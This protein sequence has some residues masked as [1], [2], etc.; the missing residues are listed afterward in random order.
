MEKNINFFQNRVKPSAIKKASD[1]GGPEDYWY[2]E[3]GKNIRP[4]S[5]CVR[6]C[7]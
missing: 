5:I 3:D 4:Y 7:K 6:E 1:N 2:I